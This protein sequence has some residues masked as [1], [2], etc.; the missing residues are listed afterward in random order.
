MLTERAALFIDLD[1][2]LVSNS[3]GSLVMPKIFAEVS[4]ILELSADKIS[5]LFVEK[6]LKKVTASDP[7]AYDWDLI[8]SEV[9]SERGLSAPPSLSFL[10]RHLSLCKESRVLDNAP[11]M[12]EDLRSRGYI[13]ILSTNGLWKY[14]ECV[15][16]ETGLI[17]LFDHIIT[18]DRA[19]CLKNSPRFFSYPRIA[20]NRKI[21]VGDN[22][23]F[24]VYYPM[25]YGMRAVHVRRGWG[26]SALYA[27]ALKI[28]LRSIEP[29]A[30]VESLRELPQ[31]LQKI[32][33]P[34]P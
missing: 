34:G 18:P 17:S 16:R 33:G 12:L 22:L 11:E 6:H 2:T 1:S 32:L 26:N 23:V 28:D 9:F 30:S 14:Q 10:E 20:A 27:K 29:N 7:G 25:L 4:K 5:S 15:L 13:L 19:G 21:S 24:D 31:A 8:L 3:L